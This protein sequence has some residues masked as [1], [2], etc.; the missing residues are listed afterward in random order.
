MLQL[1]CSKHMYIA[2]DNSYLARLMELVQYAQSHVC[3]GRCIWRNKYVHNVIQAHL[4]LS[5]CLQTA[6]SAIFKLSA[7]L[8]ENRIHR[9]MV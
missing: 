6:V 4:R 9:I 1:S 5:A 3:S 7:Y 8:Y 2:G